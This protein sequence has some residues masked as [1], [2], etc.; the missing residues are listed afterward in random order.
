MSVLSPSGPSYHD[1]A[2][3]GTNPP[4]R[5]PPSSHQLYEYGGGDFLDDPK[6]RMVMA[7][8]A[9]VGVLL[10]ILLAVVMLKPAGEGTEILSVPGDLPVAPSA[11]TNAAPL[12]APLV[13]TTLP[14]PSSVVPSVVTTD[15]PAETVQTTA[16]IASA[17]PATIAPTTAPPATPAP[18]T[19]P[20][21]TVPPTTVAPTT[22]APTTAAPATAAP[23]TAAPTGGGDGAVQQQILDS[24]NAERAKAGCGALTLHPQLNAAADAHSEDMSAQNYFSHTGLNGSKPWDRS[25]D[26]GYAG[27][28]IAENI[29]AGYGSVEQVMTG[30]MNS[31]GHKANILN[32]GYSHLG[33]GYSA[34]GNYWTQLF[35]SGG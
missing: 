4:P 14:P 32:C 23:T 29:A 5:P 8:A 11:E 21:T 10:I 13:S 19:V 20:P 12:T 25:A 7:G 15:V 2:P 31:S 27:R 24:T 35:G 16:P 18:T 28:S 9:V 26:A 6:I 22:V 1:E 3:G 17:V 33:V 30:W 34:Q